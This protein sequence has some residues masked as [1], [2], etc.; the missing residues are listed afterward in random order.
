ML[1]SCAIFRQQWDGDLHLESDRNTKKVRFKEYLVEENTTMA[2]D[3]DSQPVMSWKDKLLG[4]QTIESTLDCSVPIAGNENDFELLKG[5]VN[6]TIIDGVPVVTFSNHIKDI[7]FREMEL[8]VIVKLLG[9]NIGYNAMHNSII[10]LW[11][12][13][14]PIRLMDI[15]NGY[16]LV[17][18]Q[19][20]DDYNRVLTMVLAWIRLPNLPRYLYKRK[21]IEAI[22]GFIEK[23]VTVDGAVQ[24]VEYEA[25]PTICFACGKYGHIKETCPSVVADQN[26][27]GLCGESSVEVDLPNRGR[28]DDES[29]ISKSGEKEPEFGSWMLVEKK[30]SRRGKKDFSAEVKVKQTKQSLGTRFSALMGEKVL[31]GHRDSVGLGSLSG[32]VTKENLGSGELEKVGRMS[33]ASLDKSLGKKAFGRRRNQI[34]FNAED[35]EKIKAHYNPVFDESEGFIVPIFDNSLD[36][37]NHFKSSGNTRIPLAESMEEIA[38]LLSPQIISKNLN[39][40]LDEVVSISE[41]IN[42]L[43]S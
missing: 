29:T 36:P 21:I 41:G 19:D 10:F 5:D 30:S 26:P 7:L 34:N 13:V 27:A 4:G 11:K 3:S 9:H 38:E 43:E 25:L 20:A 1:F 37:G 39:A 32:S 18:F 15:A 31:N 42:G 40:E 2:R 33:K 17:K 8:T 12:P 35:L 14:N 22:W 24:R 23:V 6:T 28:S 16:F